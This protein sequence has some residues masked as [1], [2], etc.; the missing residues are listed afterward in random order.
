MPTVTEWIDN[1]LN[2]KVIPTNTVAFCFNL[3]EESDGSWAM[4][5]VGTEQFDLDDEDWACRETTD[6]GSREKL[7]NWEM[8]CEW[9]EALEYM[10]NE[11]KQYLLS[12]KYAALLK[13]QDGVGV[14]FVDGNIEIIYSR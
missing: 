6:F 7:Y 10:V 9:E 8:D 14:G 5:L 2:D 4:E 13:S 3:Y 12:G 11:L 1:I